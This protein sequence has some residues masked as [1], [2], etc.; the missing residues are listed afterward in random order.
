[1]PTK[2]SAKTAI[3]A[4]ATDDADYIMWLDT[5]TGTSH[6][7]LKTEL[8]AAIVSD[9]FASQA[10][11]EAGSLNTKL[12]T[13]LRVAQAIAALASADHQ[14]EFVEDTYDVAVDGAV[15]SVESATFA[16]GYVYGFHIKGVE[17]SGGTAN[18][19]MQVDQYGATAAAYV[20][21]LSLSGHLTSS[22]AEQV[23]CWLELP[24]SRV[25]TQFKPAKV[26]FYR[27][28]SALTADAVV[29][30][31]DTRLGGAHYFNTA[32]KVDKINF[33]ANGV[34]FD[35]GKIEMWR[36]PVT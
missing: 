19:V 30:S 12:M 3:L 32:Q 34:N 33:V 20:G 22:I 26:P 35:A 15:S 21:S 9:H 16:D 6:K 25:A 23:S 29:I 5:S 28:Q 8:H 36:R 7:I 31:D 13:P 27:H 24:L 4:S 18:K 1:M 11:A 10:Q 2:L 14:W 17:F